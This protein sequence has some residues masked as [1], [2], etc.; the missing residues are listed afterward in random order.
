MTEMRPWSEYFTKAVII[1]EDAV[2]TQA[3]EIASCLE[4]GAAVMIP[5]DDQSAAV[6]HVN[7]HGGQSTAEV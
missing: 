1:D 2:R 4:C 7:W 6:R 3:I 5:L